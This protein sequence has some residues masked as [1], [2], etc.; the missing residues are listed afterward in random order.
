MQMGGK[1][2]VIVKAVFRFIYYHQTKVDTLLVL[3]LPFCL[4]RSVSVVCASGR[5]PHLSWDWRLGITANRFHAHEQTA[6][7]VWCGER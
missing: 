2:D 3:P 1:T 4:R 5:D 6:A 7:G